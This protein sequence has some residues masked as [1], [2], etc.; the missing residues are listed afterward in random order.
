M[1]TD[2]PLMVVTVSRDTTPKGKGQQRP[3][4]DTSVSLLAGKRS[5][6][7][8]KGWGVAMCEAVTYCVQGSGLNPPKHTEETEPVK[9]K[10][11]C[12]PLLLSKF[13]W[14]GLLEPSPHLGSFPLSQEIY[15]INSCV[16]MSSLQLRVRKGPILSTKYL[17][18]LKRE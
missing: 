12:S 13:S 11:K 9:N 8:F 15:I 17:R 14:M 6:A 2:S 7:P 18:L 10:A 3:P 5:D 4:S 1:P 16:F